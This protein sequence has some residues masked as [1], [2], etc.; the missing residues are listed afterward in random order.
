M[1]RRLVLKP[2]PD[3]RTQTRQLRRACSVCH[4][5]QVPGRGLLADESH[6]RCWGD[7]FPATYLGV[8]MW[9][10]LRRRITA[11]VGAW[12]LRQLLAWRARIQARWN[13]GD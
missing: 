1:P 4:F 3:C 11:T 10:R 13:E 9:S 2:H 7:A 5:R 6:Y 8:A 12:V